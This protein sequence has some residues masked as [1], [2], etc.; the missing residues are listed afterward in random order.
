MSYGGPVN[1]DVRSP[2]T[3]GPLSQAPGSQQSLDA[4]DPG[5]GFLRSFPYFTHDV[6]IYL[7]LRLNPRV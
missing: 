5:R 1:D 3:P 6:N 7:P 2:G 4:S